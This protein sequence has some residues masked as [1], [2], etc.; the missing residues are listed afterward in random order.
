MNKGRLFLLSCL[1]L[2]STSVCFAVVGEI[3]GSLKAQFILDNEQVGYIGGAAIWGFTLSI[4]A[5]GPLVDAL[6]MKNLLRLA[7][8]CHIAG[9][10]IMILAM[11]TSGDTAFW[12]LFSGAL[13][14]SIA[15][16]T[17]EA[18]CNPLIATIYPEEKTKKLNQFHVWFPGGIVLGG[19]TGYLLDEAGAGDWRFVLALLF[20]PTLR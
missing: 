19:V 10:P 18:V 16:G 15:N 9:P 14:V 3:M 8:V 7:F 2:I 4:F 13:I 20:L 11:F 17:V 5:L 6:G 1:A 12:T